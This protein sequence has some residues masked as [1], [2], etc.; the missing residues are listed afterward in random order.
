M[1]TA[2][3]SITR[4]LSTVRRLPHACKLR[5]EGIISKEPDA[6][7]RSGRYQSWYK[8][9]CTQQGKS[10]IVGYVR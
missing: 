7:Y 1:L 3:T 5:L 2:I 9:K 4:R 6:P 8:I 10:V